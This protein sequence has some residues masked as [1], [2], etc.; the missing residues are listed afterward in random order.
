MNSGARVTE[1]AATVSGPAV[2]EAGL[3]RAA[4]VIYLI[5]LAGYVLSYFHR[6]APAAISDDLMRA[7]AV[8]GAMLGA[9]AATY[10]YVYTVL[11]VP[12]GVLADTA[13]P[14]TIVTA[15]AVVAGIGSMLFGLATNWQTAVA[16]RLLVGVGVAVTFV[17]VL[18]VCAN[19]FPAN[20]FATL[21][22][23]T[24]MA[25]NLG[26]V[27]AGA[28]LAWMVK[29]ASWRAVFVGLGVASLAIAA[30][31]WLVVRDRPEQRGYWRLHDS[32]PPA[33]AVHWRSALREVLA[34]PA[35]WP[36]FFVNTGVAGSYF[37]FAGLWIV[38]YL[39]EVRGLSQEAAA[40]HASL[41]MLGV[42]VGSVL[43]GVLSDRL[44]SRRGV[45]RVY[46]ALYALSWAPLLL[47]VALSPWASH[48][49]MFLMGTLVPG[50]VL[51]WTVS[52]EVNRPEHAGM[53]ISLVNVGIFLGA[54]VLQPVVGAV[55][56]TGRSTGELAAAWDRALWLLA[57]SAA[58]G[59]LCT[60]LVRPPSEARVTSGGR[61]RQDGG[62][63]ET[64]AVS[65]RSPSPE[66][67]FRIP[68]TLMPVAAKQH[69]IRSQQ[70]DVSRFSRHQEKR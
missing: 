48:A 9:I 7:F 53:A 25:G 11:Q 65:P 27:A 18:K 1:G 43:V 5:L 2:H 8:N 33:G 12:V 54:G 17:A 47:H 64:V 68:E 10:F 22:G 67:F 70:Q 6:T 62:D 46:A 28:P 58:A 16:G 13:G 37:A 42:A 56:D 63:V 60:L 24:L 4:V 31:T 61:S 19:W 30:L 49:W 59:A 21:N 66:S 41:L 23:I 50:F 51:T 32:A 57:G 44:R 3:R 39:R 40:R 34:N 14:R 52:K 35:S 69:K 15:G 38:P 45:M 36:G 55:L 26:A 29:A 20:R